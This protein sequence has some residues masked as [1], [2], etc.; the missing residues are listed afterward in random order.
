MD[1]LQLLAATEVAV[2]SHQAVD[3]PQEVLGGLVDQGGPGGQ[4]G[5]RDADTVVLRYSGLSTGPVVGCTGLQ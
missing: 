3:L 2:A 1:R 5:L 4:V